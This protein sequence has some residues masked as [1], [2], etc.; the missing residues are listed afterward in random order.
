MR[1]WILVFG[2]VGCGTPSVQQDLPVSGGESAEPLSEGVQMTSGEVVARSCGSELDAAEFDQIQRDTAEAL[3]RRAA[4][5]TST[6]TGGTIDVYFHVI[7][8][9]AIGEL[10][11]TEVDDQIAVLNDAFLTTGWTF[12]LVSTDWT[13]DASWFT[14]SSGSI[15]EDDIKSTLRQGSA[16][17]LN[18]YTWN[19]GG[20]LLGWATFPSSYAGDPTYDGVVVLYSSLPGGSAAPFDEGDTATHEVGHW[21]GLFHTFENGCKVLGDQVAD[22]AREKKAAFGCPINRNTC[23]AAGLDP[24]TNFMDYTDDSCMDNFTTGQDDRMD[25]Q[26]SLFRFGK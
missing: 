8:N 17:D 23:V 7:H 26:F 12:N 5:T 24:V 14:A 1:T 19:L 13:N 16:D 18:I 20:G 9:G 21:M 22:T 15:K 3:S 11:Q 25:D 4:T 6:V 2:L 10:T